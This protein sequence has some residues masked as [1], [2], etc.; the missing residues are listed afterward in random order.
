VLAYKI[1]LPGRFLP[2]QN[3]EDQPVSVESVASARLAGVNGKLGTGIRMSVPK[4]VKIR[5]SRLGV[6]CSCEKNAETLETRAVFKP[7]EKNKSHFWP[8]LEHACALAV[9]FQAVWEQLGVKKQANAFFYSLGYR[10]L[11]SRNTLICLRRS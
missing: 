11:F 9:E 6:G 2:F 7:Q 3:G 1:R 4:M 10:F 5:P 8:I